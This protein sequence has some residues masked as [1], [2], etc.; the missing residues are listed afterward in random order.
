[1]SQ[2]YLPDILRDLWANNAYCQSE[3]PATLDPATN[4]F[5]EDGI[6]KLS[7]QGDLPMPFVSIEDDGTIT[8]TRATKR[9]SE[10]KA[11]CTI[12]IATGNKAL[13]RNLTREYL[14]E[15]EQH[16]RRRETAEGFIDDYIIESRQ[17][18]EIAGGLRLERVQLTATIRTRRQWPTPDVPAV[19]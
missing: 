10:N 14:G 6:A 18:S 12:R 2:K 19:S 9:L 3:I 5:F 8:R 13:T 17:F 11:S 1:M 7:G 16:L 15:I 4:R